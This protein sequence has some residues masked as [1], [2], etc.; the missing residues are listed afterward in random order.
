M[1]LPI[2]LR[3]RGACPQRV[4]R[5]AGALGIAILFFSSCTGS[6][7]SG[8]DPVLVSVA[9]SPSSVQLAVG[10][11]VQVH[12]TVSNASQA[13]GWHSSN[14][15]IAAVSADGWVTGMGVGIATVTATSLED[16][17][18]SSSVPVTV[19]PPP[20]QVTVSPSSRAMAVG[21]QYRFTATVSGSADLGVTWT[22][23]ATSVASVDA[24]GIVRGVGPGTAT[25]RATSTANP[26]AWGSAVVT[27]T[28]PPAAVTIVVTNQLLNPVNIE[29]NGVVQGSVP[30]GETRQTTVAYVSPL[31]VSWTL[32][33]STTTQGTPVGDDIGGEFSTLSNPPGQLDYT[34]DAIVGNS[35]IFR[36]LIVNQSAVPL[37][38]G[39]NEGLQSQNR[40]NCVVP[41]FSS[42]TQIGYYLLYSNSNVRAY[43]SGNGYTGGYIYWQDFANGVNPSSGAVTLTATQAPPAPGASPGL[44]GAM[45]APTGELPP[46]AGA[47]SSNSDDVLRVR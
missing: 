44:V 8:T 15:A 5:L 16:P 10:E 35:Y 24:S 41:A 23:S 39:V 1:N 17:S 7:D 38:M 40:C 3:R 14:S 6:N 42:G 47:G 11:A 19:D 45:G 21:E 30:G 33:R 27:V 18:A 13:V 36:P 20:V 31:Q 9:T 32:I 46:P 29:V 12:A 4:S 43:R 28:A 22:S 34:I 2:S 25:I 37:L 26:G